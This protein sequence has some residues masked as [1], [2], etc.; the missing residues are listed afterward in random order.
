MLLNYVKA[1]KPNSDKFP[2]KGKTVQGPIGSRTV[3]RTRQSIKRFEDE[4]QLYR[5]QGIF[6]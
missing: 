6:P 2:L 5:C 3:F 1:M 4:I